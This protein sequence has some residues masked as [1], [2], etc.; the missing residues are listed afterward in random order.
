[1]LPFT[2]LF[3]LIEISRIYCGPEQH[4]QLLV[5]PFHHSTF[6]FPQGQSPERLNQRG[7]ILWNTKQVK[8][9]THKQKHKSGVFYLDVGHLPGVDLGARSCIWESHCL[10]KWAQD[11]FGVCNWDSNDARLWIINY[12]C[13]GGRKLWCRPYAA[14]AFVSNSSKKREKSKLCHRRVN[15]EL[16]SWG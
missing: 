4:S 16:A 15:V 12:S 3:F 14:E 7:E 5:K 6:P 1:M 10:W 11:I 2:F 9:K 13:S 8:K